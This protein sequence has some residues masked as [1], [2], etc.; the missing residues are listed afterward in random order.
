MVWW[1]WAKELETAFDFSR[2][3]RLGK[4]LSTEDP[5]LSHPTDLKTA[6][7]I[8]TI[9]PVGGHWGQ[10][11]G[12]IAPL[13]V[14][15]DGQIVR[16]ETSQT[17]ET[18]E[19]DDEAEPEDSGPPRTGASPFMNPK[20]SMEMDSFGLR[21]RRGS[22]KPVVKSEETPLYLTIPPGPLALRRL[23]SIAVFQT[24]IGGRGAPHTFVTFLQ[25]YPALPRVVVSIYTIQVLAR[26]PSLTRR[27][28]VRVPRFS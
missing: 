19:S 1:Y 27:T 28:V 4:L 23:P 2:R 9:T 24:S 21:Q 18:E 3:Q 20:S 16:P 22:A 14:D 15:G 12:S 10:N 26:S 8:E 13:Q 11:D 25:H 7:A 6:S 5:S 17:M